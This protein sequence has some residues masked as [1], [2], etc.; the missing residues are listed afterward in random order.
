MSFFPPYHF[1]VNKGLYVF[2]I[3]KMTEMC[4]FNLKMDENAFDVRALP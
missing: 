4:Y 2:Y 3:V 1:S